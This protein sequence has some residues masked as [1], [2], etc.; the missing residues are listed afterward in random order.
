M[1]PTTKQHISLQ[2][3]P[4]NFD[5][6]LEDFHKLKRLCP[7]KIPREGCREGTSLPNSRIG[8]NTV[9]YYTFTERLNTKGK[10][11]ASFY[12]FVENIETYKEKKFIRNMLHYYETVK[13]KNKT[14]NEYVVMKEVYNI[15][16][17]AINIFRPIVAMDIYMRYKPISVLDFTAGWGGRLV[18]AC[19]ANVP[20]YT[21]IEIN[22]NLRQP[23]KDMIRDLTNLNHTDTKTWAEM[24][25]ADALTIDYSTLNYDMVLTSPP[26]YSIE[27]YP[28]NP[29]YKSKDDMNNRFYIPL[30]ERT[31]KHLQ[32][33]GHYCLNVNKEIYTNVCVPLLGEADDFISLKKSKRQNEYGEFIY[34]WR[35][36]QA[37]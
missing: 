19:A 10:Y 16:I 30:L 9:D 4:I 22:T 35:K 5:N 28:N 29:K 25:F 18:G 32:P 12:D 26:Y 24:I 1:L 15:C 33:G 14:K 34:V 7:F 2:I 36:G 6:V 31:F 11:N 21:G 17:S 23:Y 8:N 13:N 27:Q 3:K 37:L 20:F